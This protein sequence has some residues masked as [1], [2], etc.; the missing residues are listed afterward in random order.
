M[1]PFSRISLSDQE[2]AVLR[3]AAEGMTDREIALKMSVS[4]KTIDTYWSRIRQK[5]NARNR[6]H[7]VAIA[8]R[9]TYENRLDPLFGCDEMLQQSE[10]GVWIVDRKGD[11]VFAN[12]KLADMF[13][14]STD[15]MQKKNYL[16]VLDE[17]AKEEAHQLIRSTRK[18]D[19]DSLHASGKS[20]N[21]RFKRADGSDCHVLMTT[22]PI[23]NEEGECFRTLAM[24]NEIE[25]PDS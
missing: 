14:Y 25:P 18:S 5:L 24:L 3:H 21:F 13:G 8:Y 6:T 10:E 20:F 7:A 19:D 2:S 15:E 11:T 23:M 9:E 16:D 1:D 12:K 4:E 22:T 17:R